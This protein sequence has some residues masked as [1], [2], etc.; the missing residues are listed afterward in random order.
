MSA[1]APEAPLRTHGTC[2]NPWRPSF[3]AIWAL[4]GRPRWVLRTEHTPYKEESLIIPSCIHQR[5]RLLCVSQYKNTALHPFFSGDSARA[6]LST[7]QG[8]Q[9]LA[10]R[11]RSACTHWWCVRTPSGIRETLLGPDVPLR[12]ISGAC[13]TF[14][15]FNLLTRRSFA[16]LI[17]AKIL[18][19]AKRNPIC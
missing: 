15:P 17:F 10:A 3:G 6:P 19:M 16:E 18:F 2:W 12:S 14:V 5:S 8:R 13:R 1:P 11:D 4:V 7:A 9:F